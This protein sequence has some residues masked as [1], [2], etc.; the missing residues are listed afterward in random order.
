MKKEEVNKTVFPPLKTLTFQHIDDDFNDIVNNYLIKLL[1][2]VL[3][4]IKTG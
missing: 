3:R 1:Y 2:G 4:T